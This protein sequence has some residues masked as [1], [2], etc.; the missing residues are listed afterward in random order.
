[1]TEYQLLFLLTLICC[2]TYSFEIVFGL[3]GTIIM[4]PVLSFFFS[5]KTLVIYSLLPQVIVTIIAL[6][7]SY[8]K[9]SFK[10]FFI[11]ICFA[12]TG[13]LTGG[14]LFQN[15]PHS[16]F[17]IILAVIISLAGIFLIIS[18]NFK[19]NKTVQKILDAFAGLSHALFGIS[20]PI[21]MTRLMCTFKDKTTIRN[22]ALLFYLGINIIRIINY[23]IN[24]SFNAQIIKMFYV[25]A[26]FLIIILY[27]SEKLHFKINDVI[28]K[29]IVAWIIFLCGIMMIIKSL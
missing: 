25:S 11:M 27:F 21:V 29:K 4:L 19:L 10:T 24:K 20:G 17:E 3:A 22:N 9:I 8:N 12:T 15:I 16:M 5:S 23:T 26:P 1:M 7:R 28:F 6:H 18:P 13:G 14:Y 2:L